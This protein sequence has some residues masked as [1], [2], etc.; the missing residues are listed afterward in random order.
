MGVHSG[1]GGWVGVQTDQPLGMYSRHWSP[2]PIPTVRVAQQFCNNWK[3]NGSGTVGG[4]RSGSGDTCKE[5][6]EE[7]DGGGERRTCHY[8]VTRRCTV[9]CHYIVTHTDVQ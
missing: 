5:S 8:T 9:T 6:Y 2:G 3:E 4:N 1:W 7:T